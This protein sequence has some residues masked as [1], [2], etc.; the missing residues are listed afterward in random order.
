MTKSK[1]IKILN[2]G[3]ILAV[4][5]STLSFFI[6]IVPCKFSSNNAMTF[7]LCK[8]PNPFLDLEQLTTIYYGVS[9]NPMIGITLQF[10][11]TLFLF[12]IIFLFLKK[13]NKKVLDLTIKQKKP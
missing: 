6:K 4:V 7:G 1:I 5:V 12:S 2:N 13:R 3:M 11:I 9:N 8:L 10:L